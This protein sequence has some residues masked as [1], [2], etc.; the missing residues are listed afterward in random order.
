MSASY[1]HIKPRDEFDRPVRQLYI[2]EERTP[3]CFAASWVFVHLL[4]ILPSLSICKI[5]F[6]RQ[7][8]SPVIFGSSTPLFHAGIPFF[9]SQAFCMFIFSLSYVIGFRWFSDMVHHLKFSARLLWRIVS[10][11]STTAPSKCLPHISGKANATKRWT[12]VVQTSPSLYKPTMM[13]PVLGCGFRGTLIFPRT[14]LIPPFG[15]LTNLSRDR[16]L[17]RFDIS[18]SPSYPFIALQISIY[19]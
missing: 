2:S 18:Y 8:F 16:I 3:K 6:E 10:R 7:W 13:Y 4:I 1:F 15:W 9:A 11:W 19:K 12:Y 14:S 5:G 17:P